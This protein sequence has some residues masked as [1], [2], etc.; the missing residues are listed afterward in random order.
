MEAYI[1]TARG[2]V[3]TTKYSM[4]D[5]VRGQTVQNDHFGENDENDPYVKLVHF[6]FKIPSLFTKDKMI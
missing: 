6:M 5:S 2:K 3:N 4:S 1:L